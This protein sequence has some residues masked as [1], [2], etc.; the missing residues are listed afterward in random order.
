MG[1]NYDYEEIFDGILYKEINFGYDLLP[2]TENLY[3]HRVKNLWDIYNRITDD[4]VY[5]AMWEK[6]LKE[7]M[8]RG[9]CGE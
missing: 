5:K 9:F 1:K 8:E 6:K 2:S 7:L 4:L 3:W